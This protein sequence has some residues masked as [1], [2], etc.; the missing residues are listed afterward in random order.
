[1]NDDDAKQLLRAR[2]AGSSPTDV[3]AQALVKML[4]YLPLAITQAAA[5]I[6]ENQTSVATYNE[7]SGVAIPEQE[8]S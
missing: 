5:F 2:G 7:I 3:D 8:P 6:G 1:M 4:G